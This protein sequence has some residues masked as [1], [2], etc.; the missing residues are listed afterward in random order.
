MTK[1]HSDSLL[2][3]WQVA[4]LEA[5]HLHAEQI[6]PIHLFVGLCKIVDVDLLA[7]L[8]KE[9][10]NRDALLEELLRE[11][12][13]LRTVFREADV[14]PCVLRRSLRRTCEG[15]HDVAVP[16]GRLHRND[17]S[18]DAFADAEH[19]AEVSGSAVFPIHL[20]YA[21]VSTKDPS[22]DQ[23]LSDC[24]FSLERLAA[25]AKHNT[26]FDAGANGL[27]KRASLN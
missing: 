27:G 24:G 1:S 15:S 5:R 18:K 25:T 2:F 23:V 7:L 21:I 14:D 3:V 19:F 11:T 20:L 4:E 12:R 6:E 22:R 26:F 13:R 10:P 17:A 16:K 8:S 9:T